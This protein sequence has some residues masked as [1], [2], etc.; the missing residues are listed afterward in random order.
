[1]TTRGVALI[2][3]AL[4]LSAGLLGVQL[5]SGGADFVP[6]RPADPC[7]DRGRTGTDDL[8]G[9][10]ETVVLKGL[11]EAACKL[12]VSRERLV[13]ALPSEADRAALAREI[14]TDDRGI[15]QALKDGLRAGVARLDEA[16]RLPKASVLLPSVADQLGIP[17]GLAGLIPDS[18]VD[19]LLPTADVLRR[20]LD[21]IDV[22]T[23]VAGLDDPDSLESTLRD[24]LVQGAT[25]EARARL[26]DALPGPLQGFLGSSSGSS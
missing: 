9:L 4:V 23:I 3:V 19:D 17:P 8:Q 25:D 11:D 1:M 26:K 20:S 2:A 18:V 12:G 6:Q 14:G 7:Q 5:A 15:A 10:A 21:K 16:G 13:L 22:N 24:A